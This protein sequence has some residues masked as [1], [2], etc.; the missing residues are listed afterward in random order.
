MAG[1]D[2]DGQTPNYYRLLLLPLR[3]SLLLETKI[4]RISEILVTQINTR[5]VRT[6][7]DTNGTFIVIDTLIAQVYEICI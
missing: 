4:C 3:D 1:K 6:M 7:K 2:T 5:E